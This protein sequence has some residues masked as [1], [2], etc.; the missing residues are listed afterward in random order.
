MGGEGELLR[1]LRPVLPELAAFGAA[2]AAGGGGAGGGGDGLR[3]RESLRLRCPVP[4][5]RVDLITGLAAGFA[6]GLAIGFL[7]A[8]D[9]ERNRRSH[10]LLS[11]F[12]F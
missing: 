10:T 2:C 7:Q 8:G 3:R 6:T 1:P 5:E 12:K 9:R 11:F 4:P